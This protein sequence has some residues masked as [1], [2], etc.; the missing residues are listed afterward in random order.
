MSIEP[1]AGDTVVMD[2]PEDIVDIDGV[3]V[4]QKVKWI[5]PAEGNLAALYVLE[6][7]VMADRTAAH[8]LGVY[9]AKRYDLDV[10]TLPFEPGREQNN[11]PNEAG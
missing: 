11:P 6:D 5:I 8:K 9:W 10:D 1:V 7:V 2:W 3:H 4:R